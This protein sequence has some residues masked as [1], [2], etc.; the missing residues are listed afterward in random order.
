MES[1][2]N[3]NLR[4]P[5][6][7]WA[8]LILDLRHRGEGRRESGAFILGRGAKATGYVCYDDIDPQ[9]YHRGAIAFH[10]AGYAALWRHCKANGLEVLADIH[11]HPG[12]DTRQSHIDQR[13]PMVP[14]V[15]HTALIA[16]RFAQTTIWSLEGVGIHEYL[17][18]FRWRAHA[19]NAT[20]PR[21]R[22]TW[23]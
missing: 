20:P 21:V 6:L 22:L 19:V 13:H 17:G 12:P 15:G 4:V 8:R 1:E 3:A 9:A 23:W 7:V 14:V 18:D 16:P 10:A 11:T 5:R 2:N